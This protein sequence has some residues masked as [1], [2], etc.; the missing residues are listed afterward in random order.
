[1]DV[2]S[3]IGEKIFLIL[4]K[5][6]FSVELMKIAQSKSLYKLKFIVIICYKLYIYTKLVKFYAKLYD[7]AVDLNCPPLWHHHPHAFLSKF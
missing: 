1:M 4:K 7:A 2:Q 3:T 5:G 6:D